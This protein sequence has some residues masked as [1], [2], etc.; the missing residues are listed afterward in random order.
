MKKILLTAGIALATLTSCN[1]SGVPKVSFSNEVDTLSYGLGKMAS[2][3]ADSYIYQQLGIDSTKVNN[4][5]KGF[6]DGVQTKKNK[7]KAAYFAGV[8]MGEQVS[9]RM[10]QGQQMQIFGASDSTSEFN[11][12]NYIAGFLSCL[13]KD[14]ALKNKE[15]KAMSD[16]EI[17]AIVNALAESIHDKAMVS[18]YAGNKEASTKFLAENAKKE[19]VKTL[20][21][22]VQYKVIKS[23]TKRKAKSPNSN[24]TIKFNY[25]GKTIDGKIFDSSYK[26]GKEATMNLANTIKGWQIALPNMKEGDIW[27][28]YIP[29]DV[30]YGNNETPQIKP[31]STLIFKIELIEVV[32]DK[33]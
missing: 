11:L 10:I 26:R 28:L 7:D 22:G 25:E 5:I 21:N 20:E 19:G 23:S 15:G 2:K 24:S 33:K 8:Q 13:T 16:K 31:Y 29:Y 14:S 3:G 30:A 27:E 6:V 4:F 17:E 9:G 18:A 32:D 12:N 1:N